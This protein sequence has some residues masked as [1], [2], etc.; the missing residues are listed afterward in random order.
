MN[1]E[2]D[3][4]ITF[5]DAD[6]PDLWVWPGL[7]Q[8]PIEVRD[9]DL[10]WADQ[11]S[12]LSEQIYSV[13]GSTIGSIEHV[14]ST[15]VPGLAA[16]PIIDIALV[17]ADP[18]NEPGYR[19]HLHSIDFELVIREPAQ[20]QHRMLKR[21]DPATGIPRTPMSNLHVFGPGSPEVARMRL[22]RDW[23][24]TNPDDRARYQE[25][26][27]RY[28]AEANACGETVSDYNARKQGVIRD[29]YRSIFRA[30]GWG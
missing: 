24:S 13:L 19:P 22:F 29:I 12:A 26:K 8:V 21:M 30:K 2:P 28:A 11:Y 7:P 27:L 3:E 17:V 9:H 1:V 15:S 25:A 14:G 4:I 18:D 23:L 10:C 16:K 5:S 20:H 6:D